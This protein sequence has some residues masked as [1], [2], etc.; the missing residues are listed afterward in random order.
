MIRKMLSLFTV[1][2]MVVLVGSVIV[3]EF[4]MNGMILIHG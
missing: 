2:L 4:Y 3:M 1:L